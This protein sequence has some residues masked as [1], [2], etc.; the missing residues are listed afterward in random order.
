MGKKTM[1]AVIREVREKPKYS[2][3]GALVPVIEKFFEDPEHQRDF[4]EWKK[5]REAKAAG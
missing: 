3:M 1:P 5:D 4:R 2:E